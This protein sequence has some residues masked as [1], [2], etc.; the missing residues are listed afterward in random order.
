MGFIKLI[1][2]LGVTFFIP[3]SS[4]AKI[5]FFITGKRTNSSHDEQRFRPAQPCLETDMDN[6]VHSFCQYKYEGA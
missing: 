3:I 6:W 5:N 2:G 4:S 1:S